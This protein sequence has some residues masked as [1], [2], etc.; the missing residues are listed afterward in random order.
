MSVSDRINNTRASESDDINV[1]ASRWVKYKAPKDASAL[2]KYLQPTINSAIS[3]YGGG[4]KSLRVPAYRI[5]FSALSTYDP[6]R[7]TDIKTHIHNNLKRLN[8]IQAERSNVIHVPENVAHDRSIIARAITTFTDEHGREPNDDELSDITK[9]SKKR[10]DKIMSNNYNVISSSGS[11]TEDGAD[12]VS[13]KAIS[14]D[15]YIDYLYSSS[16]NLDKKII[17]LMSGYRGKKIYS[18]QEVARRLNITP[19]AVSLR[20]T[21]LRERM[22]DIRRLV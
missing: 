1:L 9:L 13:S 5:A 16:D 19:A 15:T 3:S 18:G 20:M 6:T 11:V 14:D 12:R 10:L 21:K 7:G 22:A 4:D 2:Y 17:E 8:R